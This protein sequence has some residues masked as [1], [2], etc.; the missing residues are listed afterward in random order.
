MGL[1]GYRLFCWKL[2]IYYWKHYSKI[3]FNEWWIVSWVMNNDAYLRFFWVFGW[4]MNSTVRP[5][6]KRK[7][8]NT[9]IHLH[10]NACIVVNCQ[11]TKVSL[12]V[13]YY[14]FLGLSVL[15]NSILKVRMLLSY[16]YK[17]IYLY[18]YY[19]FLKIKSILLVIPSQILIL[20]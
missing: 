10:A 9:N 14:W 6:Q 19:N 20:I 8:T 5:N 2:K 11:S 15:R 3:I 16:K 12:Y 7:H 18:I 13:L 1:F 4:V 17:Y